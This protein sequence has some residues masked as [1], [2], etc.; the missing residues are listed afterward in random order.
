MS[1][2]PTVAKLNQSKD[3]VIVYAAAVS[4]AAHLMA[5]VVV[6]Q[7]WAAR[8]SRPAVSA[9]P[10][11]IKVDLIEEPRPEQK[12]I[13]VSVPKVVPKPVQPEPVR[14]RHL[15]TAA[16][17]SPS[18]R[19]AARPA[20]TSTAPVRT[21]SLPGNPGS[22][23]RTGSTSVNGDVPESAGGGSTPVGSVPGTG[24]GPGQG[25]GSGPGIAPPDPPRHH[26]DDGPGTRLAPAPPPPRIVSVLVCAASGM[27][28]GRYCEKKVAR[29]F[30]EGSEPSRVCTECKEPFTSTLADRAEPVLIRDAKPV[31]PNTVEEGLS[32]SVTVVFTID[33]RGNVADVQISKSS[34]NKVIDR[35][36]TDA[37]SKRKYEPAIQGG[38]PRSVKRTKTY[39]INT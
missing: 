34:G 19:A 3:R 25:S 33:E 38:I 14:I 18:P 5:A 35:A 37:V 6:G 23:L 30:T 4:I 22:R 28:P 27:L 36:V 7:T 16:D 29:S 8:L 12:P 11:F 26:V 1:Y 21:A 31:I 2:L 10:R 9:V 13:K 17:V 24:D 32:V 15:P 20:T 39:S